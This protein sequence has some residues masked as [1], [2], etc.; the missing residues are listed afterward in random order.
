MNAPRSVVARCLQ[1]DAVRDGEIR[2]LAA[3]CRSLA[4]SDVFVS[5]Y[6]L[7]FFFNYPATTEIYTLSLHDAL[8]ILRPDAVF[9]IAPWSEQAVI[10]QCIEAFLTITACSDH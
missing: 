10:E 3:P 6:H 1:R 9:I 2:C 7:F 4:H 5:L 8:P